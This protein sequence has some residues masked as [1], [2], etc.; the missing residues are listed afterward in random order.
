MTIPKQK[1]GGGTKTVPDTPFVPKP[2]TPPPTEPT[3]LKPPPLL[4]PGGGGGFIT[5]KE[6][7]ELGGVGIK[8]YSVENILF[9]SFS[10]KESGAFKYS[11][12]ELKT[13]E[14]TAAEETG[15]ADVNALL[16]GTGKGKKKKKDDLFAGLY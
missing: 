4:L 13:K 11:P 7:K 15:F 14:A 1:P 16:F 12:K 2:K 8:D 3:I 5:G 10:L 9:E 6:P